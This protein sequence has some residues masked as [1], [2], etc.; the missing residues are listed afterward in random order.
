MTQLLRAL[1]A[2]NVIISHYQYCRLK[3]IP[4]DDGI[5][6]TDC[7]SYKTFL[8]NYMPKVGCQGRSSLY[9][10]INSKDVVDPCEPMPD[11]Q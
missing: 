2:V 3:F 4:R 10:K 6:G 5:I 1:L 11:R 7:T 8:R 9:P